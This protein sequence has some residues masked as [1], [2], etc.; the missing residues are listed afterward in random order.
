M[1]S[2]LFL[3]WHVVSTHAFDV[4]LTCGLVC[5]VVQTSQTGKRNMRLEDQEEAAGGCVW[6]HGHSD[7]TSQRYGTET[8]AGHGAR[9]TRRGVLKVRETTLLR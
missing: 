9:G 2:C 5:Y 1:R 4:I 6:T 7:E 8:S 3:T